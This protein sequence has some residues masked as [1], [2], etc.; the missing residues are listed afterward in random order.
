MNSSQS[1][2]GVGSASAWFTRTAKATST[3][4]P[5]INQLQVP[6]RAIRSNTLRN[7]CCLCGNPIVEVLVG[8][9]RVP[10]VPEQRATSAR[11]VCGSIRS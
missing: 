4:P 8:L 11:G 6:G 7:V 3:M 9:G 10:T 1:S 2:C 5:R